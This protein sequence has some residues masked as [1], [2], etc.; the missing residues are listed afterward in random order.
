MA[1]RI[2]SVFMIL[3]MAAFFGGIA[4]ATDDMKTIT[5][6]LVSEDQVM[7]DDGQKYMIE[8]AGNAE[9]LDQMVDK[10]VEIKGTV[11]EKDGEKV[12]KID[13]IKPVE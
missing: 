6:T 10:K 3:A 11:M 13:S 1:R 12:L 8:D 5:G 7:A 2:I 4:S 9:N